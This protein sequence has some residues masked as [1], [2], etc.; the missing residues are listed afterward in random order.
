[1]YKRPFLAPDPLCF[2]FRDPFFVSHS[3]VP[4]LQHV[5]FHLHIL[6]HPLH[7]HKLLQ[8]AAYILDPQVP[9]RV[10]A[11]QWEHMLGT[12][13]VPLFFFTTRATLLITPNQFDLTR[14]AA[15]RQRCR[16]LTPQFS[17][18]SS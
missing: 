11:N 13:Y 8:Y 2:H 12:T 7:P 14:K 15:P 6:S 9:I 18:M 5:G 4:L 3:L 16:L 10:R 17:F 1:V